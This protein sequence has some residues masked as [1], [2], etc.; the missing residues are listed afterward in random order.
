MCVS[1]KNIMYIMPLMKREADMS[2]RECFVMWEG[3]R[4]W[5][6]WETEEKQTVW[7]NEERERDNV[8]TGLLKGHISVFFCQRHYSEHI[9]GR[10]SLCSGVLTHLHMQINMVVLPCGTVVQ[11]FSVWSANQRICHCR[12]IFQVA[13]LQKLI[14]SSEPRAVHT[15]LA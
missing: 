2:V 12:C 13:F 7:G 4:G 8:L 6:K 5:G 10:Q 15:G 3:E 9:A 14:L 11:L 1:K